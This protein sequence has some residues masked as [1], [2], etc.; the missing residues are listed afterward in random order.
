MFP[1]P[2]VISVACV[3]QC[4]IKSN[5]NHPA[6][7]L[8]WIRKDKNLKVEFGNYLNQ[9]EAEMRSHEDYADIYPEDK[10]ILVEFRK[11]ADLGEFH[12]EEES[13]TYHDAS[14]SRKSYIRPARN[15]LGS[16]V[17]SIP[18]KTSKQGSLESIEEEPE[19]ETGA[20]TPSPTKRKNAP[21][22]A[23][24]MGSVSS[25]GTRETHESLTPLGRKETASASSVQSKAS[26]RSDYSS[27]D[28]DSPKKRRHKKPG[29]AGGSLSS[30]SKSMAQ[31]SGDDSDDGQRTA[32]AKRRYTT[33]SS[34]MS[35]ANS[36]D[37][38]SAPGKRRKVDADSSDDSPS[39]HSKFTEAES[40]NT[41]TEDTLASNN[42]SLSLRSRA[43]S[44]AHSEA[45]P[46]AH[47]ASE[48]DS[49]MASSDDE[50]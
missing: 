47:S 29:P 42:P 46:S 16:S 2:R 13:A 22:S 36:D 35:A 9:L 38:K 3:P 41:L 37:D 1:F 5:P 32:P 15:S 30:R 10:M 20:S 11:H 50:N 8:S 21:S 17:S 39:V 23:R 14:Q 48:E 28:D 40:H 33:A 49:L 19:G 7:Y 12:V 44:V 4:V 25:L 34:T 43:E 6:R 26:G 31:S 27:E 45:L 24:T 18:S